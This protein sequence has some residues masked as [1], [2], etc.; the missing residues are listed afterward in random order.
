ML[1]SDIIHCASAV[2]KRPLE[3]LSQLD[4]SARRETIKFATGRGI[5]DIDGFSFSMREDGRPDR[6]RENTRD[7]LSE[8][9]KARR[10]NCLIN[11]K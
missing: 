10:D 3:P 7:T 5:L 2:R 11:K 8:N 4:F 1:F 6:Q 9:A